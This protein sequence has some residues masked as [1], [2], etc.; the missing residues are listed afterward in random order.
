MFELESLVAARSKPSIAGPV[1][2]C[3]NYYRPFKVCIYTMNIG[4]QKDA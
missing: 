1:K 4:V 2:R 3:V